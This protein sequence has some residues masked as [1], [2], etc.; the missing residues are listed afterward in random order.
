MKSR[1]AI[2]VYQANKQTK[3]PNYIMKTVGSLPSVY[4]FLSLLVVLP[5]RAKRKAVE[6]YLT[7]KRLGEE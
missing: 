5:L 7:G 4:S 6:I 2:P 1:P 3:L